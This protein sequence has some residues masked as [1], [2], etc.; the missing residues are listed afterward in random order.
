MAHVFISYSK[1][2]IEFARRLRRML[3]NAGFPVWMDETALVPSERWWRRIEENI[4]ACDSFIVVMSPNSQSSDWVEREVLLAERLR[5]PIFP[6]LLAGE[7]WSRLANIQFVPIPDDAGAALPED[8]IA[9]LSR[10]IAPRPGE[11]RREPGDSDPLA[12]P[13]VRRTLRRALLPA[14]VGTALF[15]AL[16]FVAPSLAPPPPSPTPTLS[17]TPTPTTPPALPNLSV[18]R[19][20]TSPRLPVPGQVFILS[21]T[22]LNNGEAE[23]GPF[24]WSWDASLQEPV[25]QNTL[26]GRVE[27]IPPN[28]SKNISFPV[29]YGWWGAYTT[30]LVIDVDT[31]VAEVDERDN[32]GLFEITLSGDPFEVDF[33]L[34]PPADLIEPPYTLN[35]ASYADWNLRFSLVPPDGLTCANARL[36]IG[37]DAGDLLLQV[38]GAVGSCARSRLRIDILR[39]T[40]GA[41]LVELL[42]TIG[43]ESASLFYFSSANAS[44]PL[45]SVAAVNLAAGAP[46]LIG[47]DSDATRS[48]RRIELL[49]NRGTIRITRLILIRPA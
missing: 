21:M 43:E 22:I 25:R 23:S 16:I 11:I 15:L 14:L 17:V 3:E 42:P 28:G 7:P 45:H 18:G 12:E 31:E 47:D 32:R 2:D 37:E 39:D 49:V 41:A 34:R 44:A 13:P 10:Y 36:E 30:Q 46:V 29:S 4:R 19:L 24:N 6:V 1:Q 33:A 40:V 20:R 9:G 27:S 38:E 5:K 8:L 26:V 35:A 48:I